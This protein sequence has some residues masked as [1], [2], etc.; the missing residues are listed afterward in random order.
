[1]VWVWSCLLRVLAYPSQPRSKTFEARRSKKT[2][3]RLLLL[4]V[5][6]IIKRPIIWRLFMSCWHCT[7][8]NVNVAIEQYAY[9][10]HLGLWFFEWQIFEGM[11]CHVCINKTNWVRPDCKK[12]VGLTMTFD[13]RQAFTTN[14]KNSK[15]PLAGSN[16]WASGRLNFLIW[17]ISRWGGFHYTDAMLKNYEYKD[18]AV[19]PSAHQALYRNPI[20]IS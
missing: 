3:F 9:A 18:A 4:R 1:M 11:N 10:R 16:K 5:E 13:L 2:K 15:R 19:G 12:I 8:M 7:C 14:T 17:E 20:W 6:K